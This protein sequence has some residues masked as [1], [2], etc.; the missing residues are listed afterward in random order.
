MSYAIELDDWRASLLKRS[1]RKISRSKLKKKKCRM[2]RPAIEWAFLFFRSIEM[3]VSIGNFMS[4]PPINS[5]N[6]SP[7]PFCDLPFRASLRTLENQENGNPGHKIACRLGIIEGIA[8]SILS[9][10]SFP[11]L[12]GLSRCLPLAFAQKKVGPEFQVNTYTTNDQL[13]PERS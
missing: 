7:V 8:S 12:I 13:F 2:Y 10:T 11:L 3:T 1:Q 4:Q 6:E 9:K 5:F